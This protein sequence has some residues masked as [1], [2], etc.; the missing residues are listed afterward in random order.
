MALADCGEAPDEQER[1]AFLAPDNQTG[2]ASFD[3]A[4][5]LVH[6]GLAAAVG[7]SVASET[8]ADSRLAVGTNRIVYS[9]LTR[10]EASG[11]VRLHCA[12]F[13]PHG[14]QFKREFTV[15]GNVLQVI[16]RMAVSINP[17]PNP[18]GAKSEETLRKWPIFA[19]DVGAF[20]SQCVSL[21]ES[22][23]AFGA[24]LGTC[25][26][27]LTAGGRLEAVRALL[28][29][30]PDKESRE[31]SQEVQFEFGQSNMAL[32][33][34]KK[35]ADM[36]RLASSNRPGLKNMLG[37]AEALAG[38]CEVG[39]QAIEEYG[40]IPSEEANAL[41]SLGEISFFCGQFKE[42]EKYFL[43][44][45]PKWSAAQAQQQQQG[46]AEPMKAA[47]AR[48]M[49]GDAAGANQLANS[50]LDKASKTNSQVA[51][52]IRTVWTSISNATTPDERKRLIEASLIR[53]P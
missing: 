33:D 10:A 7:G 47:A 21:A 45:E 24:A 49:A 50:Y 3:W 14:Q 39:K 53:R 44:S 9:T 30:V 6:R 41:D 15:S 52:N 13:D 38:R 46:V 22:E 25:I 35:A 18:L 20:E 43:A 48:L 2:D 36:Y 16:N 11:E 34:Y 8:V 31:F 23:P 27:Q 26:T 28:E 4:T 40:R 29:R 37:Y 5:T 32:K 42:A 1:F 12:I 19:G 17:E 51:T